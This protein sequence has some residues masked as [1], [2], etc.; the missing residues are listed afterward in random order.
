MLEV[1]AHAEEV[2]GEVVVKEEI[3]DSRLDRCEGFGG[4][5]LQPRTVVHLGVETL[6]GGES[7]VLFYEVEDVE[8][9][10]IVAAP[11]DIGKA[12]VCDSR[13]NIHALNEH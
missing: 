13:H 11:R 12:I 8:K 6:A 2:C 1:L 9:H 10:L 5:I 4:A 3:I 7:I